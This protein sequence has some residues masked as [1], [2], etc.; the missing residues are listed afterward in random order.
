MNFNR[1]AV[2]PRNLAL[3]ITVLF[4]LSLNSMSTV[5]SHGRLDRARHTMPQERQVKVLASGN[6]VSV[7][8]T[9]VRNLEDEEWLRR[10]EIEVKNVT[11]KPKIGRA[12]V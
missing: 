10:L 11:S 7:A 3:L 2:R 5:S 4:V 12:H 8:V 9:A 1:S 6:R